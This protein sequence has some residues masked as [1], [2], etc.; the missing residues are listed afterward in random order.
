MAVH[1]MTR[2]M[3]VVCCRPVCRRSRNFSVRF[4][5]AGQ[6]VVCLKNTYCL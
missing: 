4:M 3:H 2:A 5:L 1:V 6:Y